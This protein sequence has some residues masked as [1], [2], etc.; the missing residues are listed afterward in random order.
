MSNRT[1]PPKVPSDNG[2]PAGADPCACAGEAGTILV[3]VHQAHS[4]PG[5]IGQRLSVSGYG[6]D[7]RRPALGDPLPAD[8]AGYAGVVIFG[9][10]MSANDS[11]AYIREETGFSARVLAEGRPLL[12]ICLGAQIMAR[13]LGARVAPHAEGVCE[14]GY[15]PLAATEAGRALLDWPS[16]VYHWHSEGFDLPAGA[17][18]LAT[19]ET[20]PHQAFRY[21]RNAFALQF[22]P[23]VTREMM[24][25]WIVRGAH[26]FGLPGAQAGETHLAGWERY[27]GAVDRWLDRFLETWLGDA[28]AGGA[29]GRR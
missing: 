3:I 1:R 18:L 29:S 2:T 19:G 6:L 10:P 8:L 17:E 28:P 21:G 20:F 23:E 5:R 15:Y 11:H 25:V 13:A 7:V 24:S 4:T 9:G 16:H 22:H 26:R 14:I 27:D 12:G